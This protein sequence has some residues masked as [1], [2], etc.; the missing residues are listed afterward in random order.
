MTNEDNLKSELDRLRSE[1]EALKK[2]H[3]RGRELKNQ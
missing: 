3:S 2:T 1:N